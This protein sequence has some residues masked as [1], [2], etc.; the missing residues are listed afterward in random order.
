MEEVYGYR[1]A[2]QVTSWC[3]N[4]TAWSKTSTSVGY[5]NPIL[6]SC[7]PYTSHN[8][9]LHRLV[10]CYKRASNRVL[11]SGVLNGARPARCPSLFIFRTPFRFNYWHWW[12]VWPL[13]YGDLPI[14]TAVT[15]LYP[16][17]SIPIWQPRECV[18]WKQ[19]TAVRCKILQCCL[20]INT[21]V[22]IRLVVTWLGARL[23]FAVNFGDKG[24][25]RLGRDTASK[26]RVEL[27]CDAV[28]RHS[29]GGRLWMR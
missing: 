1:I 15:Y 22:M 9:E 25:S 5:R 2:S 16:V 13:C 8:T 18:K 14:F 6:R 24:I 10:I 26:L 4:A 17:R 7:N 29:C 20:R 11:Y 23:P 27:L 21:L 3:W 12:P 28:G 19:A